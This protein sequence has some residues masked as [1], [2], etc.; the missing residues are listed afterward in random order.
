MPRYACLADRQRGITNSA[1]FVFGIWVSRLARRDRGLC[2]LDTHVLFEKRSIKNFNTA[3]RAGIGETRMT[4][5][6]ETAESTL[7][8]FQDMDIDG[9]KKAAADWEAKAQTSAAEYSEKLQ[10]LIISARL[11]QEQ[12]KSPL[13]KRG[14]A[15]EIKAKKLKLDGES[16]RGLDELI[17]EMK[18]GDFKDEWQPELSN[19]LDS[20]T[21][22]AANPLSGFVPA[23]PDTPPAANNDKAAQFKQRLDTARAKGSAGRSEAI[24][25]VNE[26]FAEGVALQY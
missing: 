26:A 22:P 1:E 15:D 23:Q 21:T 17:A 12:F 9:I 4:E 16:L 2:P 20:G 19:P 18:A 7:S 3:H 11:D 13:A 5:R 24:G 25:I 14:I 6:A 8:E 10:S